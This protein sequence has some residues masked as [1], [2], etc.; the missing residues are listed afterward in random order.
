MKQIYQPAC[1]TVKN[2]DDWRPLYWVICPT[3]M[4]YDINPIRAT[5]RFGQR[6]FFSYV[7]ENLLLRLGH[8]QQLFVTLIQHYDSGDTAF[9]Q[10]AQEGRPS[11]LLIRATSNLRLKWQIY[12]IF[13]D[14][15]KSK[16]ISRPGLS[17][18]QFSKWWLVERSKIV[19]LRP[20]F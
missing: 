3:L 18:R 5:F 15:S 2:G 6:S 12:K 11:K 8:E 7:R 13:L 20:P 4:H 16:T 1:E 17:P 10:G 19:S 14:Q 9:I